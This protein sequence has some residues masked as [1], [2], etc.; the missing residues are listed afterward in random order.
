MLVFVNQSVIPR[1]ETLLLLMQMEQ[2]LLE[3][4][5]KM[6]ESLAKL[7]VDNRDLHERLDRAEGRTERVNLYAE[8]PGNRAPHLAKEVLD[9]GQGPL[10]VK[11]QVLGAVPHTPQ[12]R[13]QLTS[14]EIMR[15]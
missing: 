13:V 4:F 5:E 7:S 3:E 10:L 2:K 14:K 15:L 6:R 8:D 11:L 12:V 1:V 9:L